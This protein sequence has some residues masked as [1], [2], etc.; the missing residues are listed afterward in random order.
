MLSRLKISEHSTVLSNAVLNNASR[1]NGFKT[2]VE[3]ISVVSRD[4]VINVIG[5]TI[6]LCPNVGAEVFRLFPIIRVEERVVRGEWRLALIPRSVIIL[7][8][9]AIVGRVIFNIVIV[10]YFNN[11]VTIASSMLRVNSLAITI[12][13][14]AMISMKVVII[15]SFIQI[16]AVMLIYVIVAIAVIIFILLFIKIEASALVL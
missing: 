3:Y 5:I 12:K 2:N 9:T 11:S 10:R 1:R 6:K 8:P 16:L 4:I 13:L 7:D 14:V 15:V